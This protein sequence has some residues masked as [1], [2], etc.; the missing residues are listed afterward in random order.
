VCIYA[1][2]AEEL[3]KFKSFGRKSILENAEDIEILRFLE[4][5]T[6]VMMVE[7][8]E[9]SLAVDIPSDIKKVENALRKL[10]K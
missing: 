1:F 5:N 9:G 3:R 10:R 6:P 4:L 7:T 8:T 2:T